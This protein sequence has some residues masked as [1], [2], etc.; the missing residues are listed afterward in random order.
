M[1]GLTRAWPV[2]FADILVPVFIM[3]NKQQQQKKKKSK[4]GT[5]ET[6]FNRVMSVD[7]RAATSSKLKIFEYLN[8]VL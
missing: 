7:V 5:R 8:R 3:A 6:S 2:V 1:Y 4:E